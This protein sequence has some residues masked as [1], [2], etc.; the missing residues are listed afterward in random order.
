MLAGSSGFGLL[1]S[2]FPEPLVPSKVEK[3]AARSDR[4][5]QLELMA[6]AFASHLPCNRTLSRFLG[7]HQ[8]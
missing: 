2:A 4:S 5:C 7:I 8:S 6:F 3:E 1:V